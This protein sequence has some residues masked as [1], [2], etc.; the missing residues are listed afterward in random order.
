MKYIERSIELLEK[1]KEKIITID[2]EDMEYIYETIKNII[3]VNQ[4]G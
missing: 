3:L 4:K 1:I 2:D